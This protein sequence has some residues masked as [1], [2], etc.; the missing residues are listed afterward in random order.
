[1]ITFL[2]GFAQAYGQVWC[3]WQNGIKRSEFEG[4]EG[5]KDDFRGLMVQF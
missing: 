3:D 5:E 1:M 4:E 2:Q